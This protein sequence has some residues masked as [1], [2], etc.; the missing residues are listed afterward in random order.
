MISIHPVLLAL[1][2]GLF[3]WFTT[4]VGASGV[5]FFKNPTRKLNDTMLGFAAGVMLAASYF[6]LLGPAVE[7]AENQGDTPWMHVVP[8]FLAGGLTLW[9]IDRLIPHLHAGLSEEFSEGPKTKLP[10]SSLLLLAIT[11]HNIPEGLAVG[12]ALGALGSTFSHEAL[13]SA[14]AVAIGIGIQNIPEGFAVSSPLRMAGLS[15]K[16]AFFW[17][18]LSGIVEPVAAVL[19]AL[20]VGF[21]SSALPFA[22]SFAAGAMIFVVVEELI[23][24][25][26]C[27]GNSDNATL[28]VLA[29]FAL[30]M[31]LDVA[32]G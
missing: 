28:G 20:A 19:G 4:L 11:I 5:F 1:L 13:L 24:Q 31:L 3:T 14:L 17:G 2:A 21:F 22:L 26:Q 27:E 7:F 6:S 32:F 29:G 30:M 23:P 25:S 18:Q 10:K 9:I 8:G 16:R 12:V 15:P